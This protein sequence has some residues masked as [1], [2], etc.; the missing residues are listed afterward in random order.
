M[1]QTYHP[2]ARARVLAL[3]DHVA[4]WLIEALLYGGSFT[5]R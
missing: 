3:L 1:L 4:R 2:D 5:W